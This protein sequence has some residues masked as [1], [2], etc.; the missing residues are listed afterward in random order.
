[1]QIYGNDQN[2]VSQLRDT[3]MGNTHYNPLNTPLAQL[4]FKAHIHA[5]VSI[6]QRKAAE[7]TLLF[8]NAFMQLPKYTYIEILSFQ[9][10]SSVLAH[11]SSYRIT[12]NKPEW[13]DIKIKPP[14]QFSTCCTAMCCKKQDIMTPC[15]V[16][17]Y[18]P[19]ILTKNQQ[20]QLLP[21]TCLRVN[22][23]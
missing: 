3:L 10:A 12:T 8:V 9:V 2:S 19:N 11:F 14:L 22:C 23:N 21:K 20:I 15:K 18:A 7:I 1:M 13:N 17:H 6:L 4:N 16:Q 5:L